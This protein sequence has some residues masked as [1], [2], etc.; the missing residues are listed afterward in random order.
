[1]P[2]DR[3]GQ[4]NAHGEKPPFVKAVD[5]G[6]VAGS[7]RRPLRP[8]VQIAAALKRQADQL[9][10]SVRHMHSAAPQIGLSPASAARAIFDITE[11]AALINDGRRIIDGL[12]A[13]EATMRAVLGEN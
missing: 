4:Q 13:V 12:T 10:E 7:N 9:D 3:V 5:T 8:F 6:R 2:D 1:M 11:E